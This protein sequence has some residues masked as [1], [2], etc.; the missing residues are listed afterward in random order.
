MNQLTVL[1]LDKQ[2]EKKIVKN[3]KYKLLEKSKER[4]AELQ[5]VANNPL[6]QQ[7]MVGDALLS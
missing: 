6:V 5:E 1:L 3:I 2:K 4:V 7:N